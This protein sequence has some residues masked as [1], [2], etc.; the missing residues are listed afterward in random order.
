MEHRGKTRTGSLGLP[1]DVG[2]LLPWEHFCSPEGI[3]KIDISCAP[4]SDRHTGGVVHPAALRC[5]HTEAT[6]AL[7]V[8]WPMYS[9]H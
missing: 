1:Y 5:Q 4:K 2:S 7:G 3:L 9:R 8:L 6:A